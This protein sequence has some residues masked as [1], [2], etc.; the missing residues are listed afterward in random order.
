MRI[1]LG[2]DIFFKKKKVLMKKGQTGQKGVLAWNFVYRN[3][4]NNNL[5]SDKRLI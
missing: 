2:S 4:S 5:S 1:P 3:M